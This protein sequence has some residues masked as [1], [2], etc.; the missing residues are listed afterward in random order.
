MYRN[1]QMKIYRFFSNINL[2]CLFFENGYE[3]NLAEHKSSVNISILFLYIIILP[4]YLKNK[5]L[6]LG[7]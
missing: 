3:L 4:G 5:H 7:V 2:F 6:D 1:S